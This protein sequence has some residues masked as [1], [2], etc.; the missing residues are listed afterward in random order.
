MSCAWTSFDDRGGGR[1]LSN[2]RP[3][4]HGTLKS[5]TPASQSAGMSATR[6]AGATPGAAALAACGIAARVTILAAVGPSLA[7]RSQ[8]VRAASVSGGFRARVGRREAERLAIE[9]PAARMQDSEENDEREEQTP[10][11]GYRVQPL[12]ALRRLGSRSCAHL[13]WAY[14]PRPF[15]ARQGASSPPWRSAPSVATTASRIRRGST[16]APTFPS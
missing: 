9:V 14:H 5:V 11:R 8:R 15:I 12:A 1:H 4:R 6:A 16:M 13:L 3:G 2:A 10:R 7:E